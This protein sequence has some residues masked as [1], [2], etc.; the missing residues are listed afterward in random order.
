MRQH[1]TV[2]RIVPRQSMAQRVMRL[3]DVVLAS[4]LFSATLPLMMIVAIAIKLESGGAI[5]DKQTRIVGGR[6]FRILNFRTTEH[7]PHLVAPPWTQTPTPIGRFLRH[8][9]IEVLPQLIN[10]VRGDMS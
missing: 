9:R 1:Q 5:L 7:A 10:V 8:T 3:G 4:L 6:R 2:H